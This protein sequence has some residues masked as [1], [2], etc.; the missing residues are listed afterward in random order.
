MRGCLYVVSTPIGN[1]EDITLRGLKIL[2]E[3]DLVIAEDTRRTRVLLK[4]YNIKKPLLSYHE[5]NKPIRTPI[6]IDRLKSG[7][8]VALVS[9][10]GTP[11]ICDPGFYLIREAIKF[12]L[13]V[14]PI[15][16]ATA[17]IA[18]L[19]VSGLPTDRFVFEG[20][21]PKA[22][23]KRTKKLKSLIDEP[24][25]IIFFESPHRLVTSLNDCLLILGDRRAT[26]CRELTKK[27]ETIDRGN[28]SKLLDRLKSKVNLPKGEFVV[29]VEGCSNKMN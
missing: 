29:V 11:G 9:D 26:V 23:G 10:S 4:H 12:D 15:P 27:F 16:G 1:F 6:I 25:T 14:I 20:W 18:G 22:I 28:I 21:L 19:I 3:V 2:K 17:I 5:H 8:N 13:R 24:R 7:S